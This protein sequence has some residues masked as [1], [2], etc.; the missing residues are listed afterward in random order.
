MSRR[1]LLL[2]SLGFLAVV[3]S[4][5]AAG[6]FMDVN[7]VGQGMTLQEAMADG[8][9]KAVEQVCVKVYSASETRDF[10]LV[11]DTVLTRSAGFV[12]E[13]KVLSQA[14]DDDMGWEVR[15]RV[16]VLTDPLD[17][18]WGVVTN[19][20]QDMGRPKIMVVLTEKVDGAVLEDSTVQTVVEQNLLQSGFQVVGREMVQAAAARDLQAAIASDDPAA[21]QAIAKRFDAPI[22]VTGIVRATQ[23]AGSPR[24]IY[25]M[26][27]YIY[28]ADSNVKVYRT[29]TGQMMSAVP[30]K[31]TR[32]VQGVARSAAKQAMDQQ[33]KLVAPAITQDILR[34]WMD[35]LG[36]RGEV[37]LRVS[38]ISFTQYAKLKKALAKI[39][40]VND[41]RANYHNQI[42]DM[43]IQTNL[44]AEPLG[45]KIVEAMDGTLEITDM[46]QNTLKA[47]FVK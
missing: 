7:V 42:A 4:A 10:V 38:N 11:K 13:P 45:L 5:D 19:L 20:L 35:A 34:F 33:G 1:M 25:G 39:E 21:V 43:S 41:V 30:A 14:G 36:G 47:Q 8:K 29:D 17:D 40:G 16:T 44:Q 46:N 6:K 2:L 9:R 15:M 32:G 22:F 27:R 12:K 26:T 37:K 3:S 18:L 23:A 28:E 31:A 24:Q